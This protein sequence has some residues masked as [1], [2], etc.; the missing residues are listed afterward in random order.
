MDVTKEMTGELSETLKVHFTEEDFK[1]EVEKILKDY[2]RKANIPGFRPGK[3]PAGMIK[4]M[5]GKAVTADQIDK[6]VSEALSKYLEE[7][8][9]NMLGNP[10]PNKDLNKTFD[11]DDQK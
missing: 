7:N 2:Q 9:V 3:V 10:L 11:L 4:K 6:I 1:D 5:Y 8:K